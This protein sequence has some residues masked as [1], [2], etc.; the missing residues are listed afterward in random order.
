MQTDRFRR[1]TAP[2]EIRERNGA[3]IFTCSRRPRFPSA[4][5]A[6]R[7]RTARGRLPARI[8]WT[9]RSRRES[10]G[11]TVRADRSG[12]DHHRHRPEPRS[13]NPPHRQRRPSGLVPA[14]P[15]SHSALRRR[16]L[17]RR[18]LGT[19]KPLGRTRSGPGGGQGRPHRRGRHRHRFSQGEGRIYSS[20]PSHSGTHRGTGGRSHRLLERSRGTR[21]LHPG[22]IVVLARRAT[23]TPCSSGHRGPHRAGEHTTGET[24]GACRRR[25][26]GHRGSQRRRRRAVQERLAHSA[27]HLPA[28]RERCGGVGSESGCAQSARRAQSIPLE[29]AGHEPGER[30]TI[31]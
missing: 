27:N 8:A 16:T 3:I 20:G 11:L 4:R 26:A 14:P 15:C 18:G 2:R 28:I 7:R 29:R 13:G 31:R 30:R 17:S 25:T 21:N 22:A 6:P 12:A 24:A 1:H 5:D 19:D 10:L 9:D 23:R